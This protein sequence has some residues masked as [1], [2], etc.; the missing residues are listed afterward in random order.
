MLQL[1]RRSG[2][3]PSIENRSGWKN[4]LTQYLLTFTSDWICTSQHYHLKMSGPSST[5]WQMTEV[6]NVPAGFSIV[7]I[8]LLTV[9]VR[10]MPFAQP[11]F[12]LRR[13]C[14]KGRLL[15][16]GGPNN[17]EAIHEASGRRPATL[18]SKGYKVFAVSNIGR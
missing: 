4:H 17:N 3:A 16:N 2:F 13:K 6:K 5:A 18:A 8:G 12:L 10:H 14:G 7:R 1:G 15:S 9:D 11:N